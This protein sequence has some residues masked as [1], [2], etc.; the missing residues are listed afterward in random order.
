MSES[1]QFVNRCLV[2]PLLPAA[3]E[4]AVVPAGRLWVVKYVS[5]TNSGSG[6]LVGSVRMVDPVSLAYVAMVGTRGLAVLST[7]AQLGEWVLPAGCEIQVG[8]SGSP[9]ACVHVS[10]L[11]RPA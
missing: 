3:L 2:D 1:R 4:L 7:V 11:D 10:G 6:S 8:W 5:L 9:V